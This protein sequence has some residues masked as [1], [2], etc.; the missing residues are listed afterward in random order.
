MYEMEGALPGSITLGSPVARQT[1]RHAPPASTGYPREVP[2]SRY[3]PRPGVAPG[4][5]P[6]PNGESISTAFPAVAQESAG[7]NSRFSP[8]HTIS[9]ERHRLSARYDGYPP[10]YAQLIH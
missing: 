7:I 2:V 3:L 9:T 6:F 5:F 1:R 10:A 8:V 4:R